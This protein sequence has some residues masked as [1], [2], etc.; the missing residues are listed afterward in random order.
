MKTYGAHPYLENLDLLCVAIGSA[1]VV[2]ATGLPP[3]NSVFMSLLPGS[4]HA[5]TICLIC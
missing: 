4:G 5:A 2:L 1:T 3:N